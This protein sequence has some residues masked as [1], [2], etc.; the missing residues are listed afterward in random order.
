M[1]WM[2]WVDVLITLLEKQKFILD[3]CALNRWAVLDVV[4]AHGSQGLCGLKSRT[5]PVGLL[6]VTVCSSL[7]DALSSCQGLSGSYSTNEK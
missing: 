7:S 1:M 3:H 6:S 2:S 5:A 4:G